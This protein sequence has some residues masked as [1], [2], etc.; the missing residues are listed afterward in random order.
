VIEP[1][2]SNA[3]VAEIVLDEGLGYAIEDYMSFRRIKEPKLRKLWQEAEIVLGKIR[4][5]LE[6]VELCSTEE[7]DDD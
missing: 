2:L 7:D 5:I 6:N 3:E 1:D 4:E